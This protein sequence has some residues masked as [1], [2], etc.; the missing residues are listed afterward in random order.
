MNVLLWN[1]L[2]ILK[3]LHLTE[4]LE[5]VLLQKQTNMFLHRKSLYSNMFYILGVW[6]IAGG[7]VTTDINYMIRLKTQPYKKMWSTDITF[8]IYKWFFWHRLL[9][10]FQ[11]FLHNSKPNFIIINS[12]ENFKLI[13]LIPQRNP[14][15]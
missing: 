12:Y 3:L 13:E 7:D 8:S 1:K 15:D 5:I 10:Q 11:C 9:E 14:V 2:Q 6:Y 4:T